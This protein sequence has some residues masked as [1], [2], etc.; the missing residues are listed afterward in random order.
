MRIEE[1]CQ[2]GWRNHPVQAYASRSIHDNLIGMKLRDVNI[3]PTDSGLASPMRLSRRIL[4]PLAS[5]LSA[6]SGSSEIDVRTA[7]QTRQV[8]M[9]GSHA[10]SQV[11]AQGTEDRAYCGLDRITIIAFK[12]SEVVESRNLRCPITS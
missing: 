6:L 5:V 3:K 1:D 8:L 12:E 11:R 2:P 10:S 9:Q 4:A 7:T